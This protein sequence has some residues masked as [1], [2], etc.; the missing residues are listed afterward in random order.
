MSGVSANTER[1]D[2]KPVRAAGSPLSTLDLP[3][4]DARAQLLTNSLNNPDANGDC[5]P[6]NCQ[7]RQEKLRC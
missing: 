1:A 6:K 4:H 2:R 7:G 3:N 5:G